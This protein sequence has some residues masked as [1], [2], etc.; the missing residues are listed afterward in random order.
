M[1]QKTAYRLERISAIE[2]HQETVQAVAILNV[3]VHWLPL[4]APSLHL[5]SL[6]P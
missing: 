6:F 3:P 1:N 5:E 4:G 2:V